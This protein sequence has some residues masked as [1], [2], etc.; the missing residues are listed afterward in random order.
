MTQAVTA[1]TP[2]NGSV[3]SAVASATVSVADNPS[4]PRG[5]ITN[6]IGMVL[7]WIAAL[8]G[9]ADGGYVSK[10]EVSQAEFEKVMGAN[11]SESKN[12]L[13]PVENVT[14][15]EAVAFCRKLTSLEQGRAVLSSALTYALPTEAQWNFFLADAR[16]EDAVTSRTVVHESP[17]RVGSLA[18]NKYGLYDVLGNVWEFCADTSAAPARL[19]HGAAFNNRK[20]FGDKAGDWKPLDRTTPR[21]LGPQDRAPDAGFRCVAFVP[22]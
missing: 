17:A 19:L 6:T 4:K 16:F 10:Y 11:P 14:W 7:V 15:E 9:C 18:P 3:I 22:P 1:V 8:P 2:P 20:L 5:S 13:Q 21:R 12:A